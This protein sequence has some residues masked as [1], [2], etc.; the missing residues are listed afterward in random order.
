MTK[1]TLLA[2]AL[3]LLLS[4]GMA[5]AMR[6]PSAVYCRALGYDYETGETDKGQVGYCVLPDG[7]VPAWD[8]LSG[9]A[10]LEHSYC[11][12]QGYEAKRVEASEACE[13]CTVCVVEGREIEVTELMGLSFT[14][15][16]CGDGTCGIPE[17]PEN[18][19]QDCA[20]EAEERPEA[21]EAPEAPKPASRG[22]DYTALIILALMAVIIILAA[23]I[24]RKS[25]K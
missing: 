1:K 6:N 22:E 5:G 21:P 9:K 24:M 16:A 11:A 8:F 4:A 18:C 12:Q 23:L 17:T 14:E 19:P 7:K 2:A 20:P 25:R 13:D 10:G 15:T 3:A